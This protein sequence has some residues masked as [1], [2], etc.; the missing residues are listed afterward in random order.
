MSSA[1][2]RLAVIIV[3]FNTMSWLARCLS[4]LDRQTIRNDME[5]IVVDNASDDDSVHMVRAE[6][7][8]C[9]LVC[10]DENKGFG[11]ANNAGARESTAATLLFLNPDT[12]IAEDRCLEEF[13]AVLERHPQVAIAAGTLHD[14][15]GELERSTGCFPTLTSLV[16]DR[17]LAGLP[18]LR[19]TLG[20]RSARHWH[21]FDTQRQVDWATAAALWVRTQAFESIGG[22]DEEIFMYYDD[23]DLCYRARSDGQVCRY[24]PSGPITHFR[25]KAPTPH[26]RKRLQRNWLR[27]FGRK[28]YR[29]W[30]HGPTRLAFNALWWI[31][32]WR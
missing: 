30:R 15:E 27:H 26:D 24:Y 18:F 23:V 21:G 13:L 3:N 19:A 20:R 2:P 25:N 29:G 31:S 8:R 11:A 6:F 14:G 22:F 12:E 1:G 9:S 28:H 7:P 4:S 5:V 10:L 16:L 32:R 17:V